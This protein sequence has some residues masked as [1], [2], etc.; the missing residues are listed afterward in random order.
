MDPI[1]GCLKSAF[2]SVLI[3]GSPSPEFS[4]QKGLRQGY[5]LAL[6]LFNIVAEALNGPMSQAM[7]KV[8]F[9]GFPVGLNKVEISVLQY[10]D[11]TIFFGEASMQ[12]VKAIKAVLRTFELV[13]SLKINFVKSSFGA[14]GMSDQWKIEAA[15][16][17]NCSLLSFPF[18]YLGVPIRANLRRCQTWD[19]IISKCERKLV[20]WK[21]RH[22]C[23][24]GRVTLIQSVLTS[25]AMYFF[26]FFMV[27]RKVEDKLVRLQ[28]RFLWGGAHDQNKI[29]WIKWDTVYLPKERGGGGRG[30]GIKDINTFNLA[31]L[32]KWKWN[33][34]QHQQ[35]LWA[36][37]LESKYG[38]WRSLNEAPRVNRES[39]WWRDLKLAS[40]HPQ[41]DLAIH[42][43]T[44]WRIG[45]GDKFRFWEDNWMGGEGPLSA[46]YPRLYAI[47]RQ[48]NQVIQQ[49]GS[50]R[51]TR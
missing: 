31:L 8:I 24:G 26:S 13:S 3:N 43:A 9:R 12:N 33:L 50:Y 27:P 37:V 32:G 30:V 7:G 41:L 11:D 45:C 49:M 39:I 36:R 4:P 34:F 2:V 14:L 5:P 18:T 29:A 48:Q 40:Q 20:K 44:T 42:N 1:E 6:L 15:N 23:F 51:D 25:I 16:Y 47:S 10:A 21:Q 19:P 46:K 38:G 28:G 17:L 35:E 22:L